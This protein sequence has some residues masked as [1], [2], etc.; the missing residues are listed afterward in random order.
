[1]KIGLVLAKT[2]EY[3][4][5]F[6]QS[7]IKGLQSN[8]FQVTLYVQKK[9]DSLEGVKVKQAYPVFK[10]NPL[11]FILCAIRV[12]F[13]LVI[14]SKRARNFLEYQRRDGVPFLR[15][16]K[17]LYLSSHIINDQLD[18]LHFGFTTMAVNREQ[19]AKAMGA[20]MAVSCRGYD[21][22]TYPI[23]KKNPYKEV[24][25]YV[26]KVHC[27]SGYMK[28]KAIEMGLSAQEKI[29]IITPA[30]EPPKINPLQ[31]WKERKYTQILTVARLHQVKGIAYILEALAILKKQGFLFRYTVIGK[32]Q[33]KESLM[34]LAHKL[35]IEE[36]V[37]FEGRLVHEETLKRL[38]EPQIYIQYSLSEGFCNAV[39]EAQAM[40]CLCIVSNGGAL[41]E[42]VLDGRTGWVVPKQ[43]PQKLAEK[44][45]EVIALPQE[46]KETIRQNAR[47]RV[48]QEFNLQKQ[49]Q[50]FVE[51]YKT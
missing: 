34:S 44:I 33:E 19:L 35:E 50:E 18:W 27:I 1:M 49:A 4:E 21:L 25:K 36:W 40:G 37:H 32:G 23:N 16:L 45:K 11:Q 12:I 30:L 46:K 17:N 8:S 48:V 26:D 15:R 28:Q 38:Q 9:G 7:K 10:S 42:N 2:P 20:K 24:W 31:G 13:S 6:F 5:T 51:F 22:D 39:L 14:G 47:Q 3:S 41:P 43:N 29:V